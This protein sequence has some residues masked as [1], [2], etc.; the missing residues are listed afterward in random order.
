M[1]GAMPPYPRRAARCPG[2]PRRGYAPDGASPQQGVIA[3][4]VMGGAFPVVAALD[5]GA[6][7]ASLALL[8]KALAG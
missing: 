6:Q 3:S 2:L 1:R 7:A 8:H 5:A 4:A